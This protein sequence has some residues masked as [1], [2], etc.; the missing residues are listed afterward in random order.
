MKTSIRLEQAVQK[1]YNAFY[2]NELHPECCKQCAVGNILDNSDSWKHLSDQHGALELN[3]LGNVHQSFGRKFNGYTPLELLHIEA[4]FLRACGYQLPFHHK[5]KKPKNPTD[6][7]VLF[8]GL[9]AVVTLLCSLDGIPNFMD[10]TKLFEFKNEKPR[11]QI[12]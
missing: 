9:T 8:K 1:L 6:K 5:N 7:D 12:A 2:N 11:F 4:T 3:Y 10:Y